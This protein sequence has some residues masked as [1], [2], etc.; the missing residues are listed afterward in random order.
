MRGGTLPGDRD[1][2][3]VALDLADGWPALAVSHQLGALPA[4]GRG[5]CVQRSSLSISL[6]HRCVTSPV[7]PL[8]LVNLM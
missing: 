1:G 4:P 2:G 8:G 3:Q 5:K 7:C 6:P